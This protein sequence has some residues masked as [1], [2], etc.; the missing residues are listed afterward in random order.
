MAWSCLWVK[1]K[2]LLEPGAGTFFQTSSLLEVDLPPEETR[3]QR[4]R[5]QCSHHPML[6]F[7]ALTSGYCDLSLGIDSRTDGA[8]RLRAPWQGV[9]A[10]QSR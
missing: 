3:R 1:Q 8:R 2:S 4:V 9:K 6:N 5:Q 7:P 10:L